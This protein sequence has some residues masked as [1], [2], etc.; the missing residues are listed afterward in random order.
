MYLDYLSLAVDEH[1]DV[2]YVSGVSEALQEPTFSEFERVPCRT[3][4]VLKV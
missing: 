1:K 3:G 4:V 2:P